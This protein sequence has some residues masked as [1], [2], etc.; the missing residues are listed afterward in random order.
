MY[1]LKRLKAS[2]FYFYKIY[3]D[4]HLVEVNESRG[5]HAHDPCHIF[6]TPYP[7]QAPRLRPLQGPV[8]REEAPGKYFVITI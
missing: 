7:R 1:S 8:N 3:V 6:P 5:I 2:I 4:A